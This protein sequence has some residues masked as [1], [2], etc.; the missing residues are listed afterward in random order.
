MYAPGIFRQISF[1]VGF[2]SAL[3]CTTWL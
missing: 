1:S 3:S 2:Q